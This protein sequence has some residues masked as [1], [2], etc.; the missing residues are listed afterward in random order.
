MQDL[1]DS[2][3]V[4]CNDSPRTLHLMDFHPVG[5]HLHFVLIHHS[6]LI[7]PANNKHLPITHSYFIPFS[8]S[9]LIHTVIVLLNLIFL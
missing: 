4:Y 8:I 6:S 3:Q 9:N 2:Y 1:V 7:I 5:I